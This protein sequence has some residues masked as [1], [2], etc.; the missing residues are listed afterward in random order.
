MQVVYCAFWWRKG[1]W[2]SILRVGTVR[3]A[4]SFLFT[5]H[6]KRGV[7][8]MPLCTDHKL[9]HSGA[10][11]QRSRSNISLSVGRAQHG[12]C[13]LV[14]EAA[15]RRRGGGARGGCRQGRRLLQAARQRD[16]AHPTSP[17]Q[18][19]SVFP[20]SCRPYNFMHFQKCTGEGRP[21]T[22]H[23][24]NVLFKVAIFEGR[25]GYHQS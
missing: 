9:A 14:L 10:H 11:T 18:A 17:T 3:S 21:G 1:P 13:A 8:Q 4:S 23:L 5:N 7:A 16:G 22:L 6:N 25:L 19:S 15:A 24:L 12:A 20:N 2:S